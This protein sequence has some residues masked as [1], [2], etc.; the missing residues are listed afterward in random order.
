MITG[1]QVKAGANLGTRPTFAN[2]GATILEY[3]GIE[4]RITGESCLN[5]IVR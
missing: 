2:I 1:K 5:D 3:F 4:P